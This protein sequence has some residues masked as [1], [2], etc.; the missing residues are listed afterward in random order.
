MDNFTRHLVAAVALAFGTPNFALGSPQLVMTGHPRQLA[1][2]AAPCIIPTGTTT[3]S[4]AYNPANTC[5]PAG[6]ACFN[7]DNIF[8]VG[9]LG[10]AGNVL[11]N[12]VSS[13]TAPVYTT[14]AVG[15]NPAFTFTAANS[16]ILTYASGFNPTGSPALF[17]AV[18]QP[19]VTGT[20]PIFASDA[21][22]SSSCLNSIE[23]TVQS[24]Q[25][26]VNACFIKN[27]F[28]DTNSYA[29]VWAELWFTLNFSTNDYTYGH[30][31][32][33]TGCVQDGSGNKAPASWGPPSNTVGAIKYSG[34]TYAQGPL[35]EFGIQQPAP[36][37]LS[38]LQAY[39]AC[40]F[41]TI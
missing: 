31:S 19:S 16:T 15:T 33:A 24:G 18:L 35:A 41:T 1:S 12:E 23:W 14:N 40:Q 25:S 27:I 30:C 11:K 34:P 10:S 39:L 4:A 7:T 3:L 20:F 37:S 8:D 28:T 38:D 9:D 26:V 6:V 5:W 36:G 17:W 22:I 2:V 21:T 29:G 13:A 32:V